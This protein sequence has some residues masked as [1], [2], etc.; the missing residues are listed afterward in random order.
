MVAS[1]DVAFVGCVVTD[2]T[3]GDIISPTGNARS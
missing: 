2:A 1:C 3:D